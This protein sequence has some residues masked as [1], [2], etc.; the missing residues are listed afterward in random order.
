M[1]GVP[2]EVITGEWFSPFTQARKLEPIDN[3][4]LLTKPDALPFLNS[5]IIF[6]GITGRVDISVEAGSLINDGGDTLLGNSTPMGPVDLRIRME[7]GDAMVVEAPAT[8][9]T[10]FEIGSLAEFR[11]LK[12]HQAEVDFGGKVYGLNITDR[13]EDDQDAK[14]SL[15]QRERITVYSEYEFTDEEGDESIVWL[16]AGLD[17]P[18]Q[19]LAVFQR[20]R[21]RLVEQ[22]ILS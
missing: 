3:K 8:L 13:E 7:D 20:I 12:G 2:I 14:R 16:P 22:E 18:A 11:L 5:A 6:N 17:N 4:A 19:T 10:R 1:A 9:S 21:M 15:R